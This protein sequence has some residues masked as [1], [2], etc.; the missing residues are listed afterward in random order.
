[1]D[2]NVRKFLSDIGRKGG[3]KRASNPLRIEMARNAAKARWQA[4]KAAKHKQ[5]QSPQNGETK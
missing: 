5:C 1:M 4:F 3:A 2:K